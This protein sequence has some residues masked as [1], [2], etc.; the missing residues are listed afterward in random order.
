MRYLKPRR[1]FVSII[2]LIS[3]LGVT[4]GI[5][6]MIVVISVMTGF[7]RDLKSKVLG[8]DPHVTITNNALMD[9]WRQVRVQALKAPGVVGVSPFV[10]GP[11]LAEFQNKRIAPKIRGIDP[12]LEP[13]EN[14]AGLMKAGDGRHSSGKFDLN[15]Q[16]AVVGYELARTLELQVGDKITLYSPH[17]LE[18]VAGELKKMEGGG[19]SK[20]KIDEL[21]EAVLPTEVTVT[22]IFDSGRYLYDSEFIFVPLYLGQELYELGDSVHGLSVQTADPYHADVVKQE[23]VT[24]YLEPPTTALTWM[25]L[26]AQFFDAVRVE[27]STMFVILFVVLIVAAFCVMNTL[28]TVTVQK[29]RE[30]GIMKAIGADVWQVVRVFVSQGMVVGTF[31]VVSGLA[32]GLGI[33]AALNPFKR[34]MESQFGIVLFPKQVYGLGEIPYWTK[35][36]DVAFICIG[37]FLI[38]SLAALIPAVLGPPPA[39]A[40]EDLDGHEA[41]GPGHE[42]DR[43]V[44]RARRQA[45][46]ADAPG[47]RG[48]DGV[49]AVVVL[50]DDRPLLVA[51][52]HDRVEPRPHRRRVDPGPDL[53]ARLD[54]EPVRVDLAFARQPAVRRQAGPKLRRLDRLGPVADDQPPGGMDPVDVADLDERAGGVRK[55]DRLAE[56]PGEAPA[57]DF[58]LD[59]LPPRPAQ[60]EDGRRERRRVDPEAVTGLVVAAVGVVPDLDPEPPFGRQGDRH[61]A[62]PVP[63]RRLPPLRDR[64]ARGGEDRDDRRDRGADPPGLQVERP[65]GARRPLDLELVDVGRG[66]RPGHRRARRHLPRQLRPVVRLDLGH[67]RERVDPDDRQ[68]RQAVV[69]VDPDL[70]VAR[71]GIPGHPELG[72]RPPLVL[73]REL[74]DFDPAPRHRERPAFAE[75]PPLDRPFHRPPDRRTRR[76][77]PRQDRRGRALA[78]GRRAGDET[79]DAEQERP[80]MPDHVA[81][82][83]GRTSERYR[84]SIVPG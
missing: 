7:D 41:V 11:V 53:L 64:G 49:A 28:I 70:A 37:A 31:G 84:G 27:R 59:R 48:A 63:T 16:S 12:K 61:P 83:T 56:R 4:L 80:R 30:I 17:N 57:R 18:A 50:G 22:G 58:D 79:G 77:D 1:T 52:D 82:P 71:R 62:I 78:P 33:L 44:G 47:P 2:T 21:R 65:P 60:G 72:R 9:D 66:Q 13:P 25:D 68:V 74:L 19:A 32:L 42:L 39:E 67:L 43:A 51:D 76:E 26:N 8:F 36:A 23:L 3:I 6:V 35:P 5:A 46:G 69:A 45:Q 29:T 24:K 14:L 81:S 73:G 38:C 15:G 10:M 75:I 34:V 55:G 54:R 20:E 40:V